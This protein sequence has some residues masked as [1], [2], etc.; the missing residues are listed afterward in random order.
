MK[1]YGKKCGLNIT[2]YALRHTAALFILRHGMDVFSLQRIMGHATM[3][4][5]R[6]YVNL[7][8]EDTRKAHGQAGVILSLVEE[9]PG[10]KKPKKKRLRRITL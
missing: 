3:E 2:G 8:T 10:R 1:V 4:M 7:T 6:H 9:E 5:T